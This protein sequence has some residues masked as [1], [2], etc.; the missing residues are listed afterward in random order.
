MQSTALS[1]SVPQHLCTDPEE[2]L[3][4]DFPSMMVFFFLITANLSVLVNQ[5]QL[6]QQSQG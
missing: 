1:S 4:N 6:S 2:I 5:H 3:P